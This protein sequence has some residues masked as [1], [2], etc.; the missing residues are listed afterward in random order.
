[1]ISKKDITEIYNAARKLF[2]LIKYGNIIDDHCI[3]AAISK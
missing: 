1:M 2:F 3:I